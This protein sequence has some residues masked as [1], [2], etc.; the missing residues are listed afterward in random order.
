MGS[1]QMF[2]LCQDHHRHV[3]DLMLHTT[4]FQTKKLQMMIILVRFLTKFVL[5]HSGYN[6][7]KN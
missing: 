3:E 1:G 4:L 6:I 5:N 2:D 7:F